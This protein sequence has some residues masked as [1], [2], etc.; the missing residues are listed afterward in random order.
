MRPGDR[1]KDHS[2]QSQ[3]STTEL[4]VKIAPKRYQIN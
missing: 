1:N 3:N 2:M 4:Q